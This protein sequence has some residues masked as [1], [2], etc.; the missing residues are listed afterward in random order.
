MR[1]V[2]LVSRLLIALALLAAATFAPAL[3]NEASAD[4]VLRISVGGSGG[5]MVSMMS[6][7]WCAVC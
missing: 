4:T 2:R 5:G 3:A 1:R 6:G 7:D